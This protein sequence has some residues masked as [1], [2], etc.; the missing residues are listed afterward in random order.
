[1]KRDTNSKS[2]LL[3]Q[4][5]RELA[6]NPKYLFYLIGILGALHVILSVWCK[7]FAWLAS[8]GGMLAVFGLITSFSYSFPIEDLKDEDK[9][10][11]IDPDQTYALGGAPLACLIK[12]TE[13]IEDLKDK[14]AAQYLKKYENMQKFI[15]ITVCGAILSSYCGHLN[16]LMGW[17]IPICTT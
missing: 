15:F 3:V 16:K 14:K 17:G 10:I 7:D 1:M 13:Q 8:Y 12:G 11:N 6:D 5:L 9:K 2:F 4:W